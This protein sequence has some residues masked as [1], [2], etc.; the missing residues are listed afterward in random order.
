MLI[1]SAELGICEDARAGA[2]PEANPAMRLKGHRL[3]DGREIVAEIT[4]IGQ[5]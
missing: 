1:R 3:A 4:S 5:P 2:A